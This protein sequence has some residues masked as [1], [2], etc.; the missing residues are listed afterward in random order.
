[1]WGVI[2]NKN[3]SN[4]IINVVS[5]KL[6]S[7][8]TPLYHIEQNFPRKKIMKPPFTLNRNRSHHRKL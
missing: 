5:Q 7:T 4:E 8:G 6:D 1:M 3:H 2:F